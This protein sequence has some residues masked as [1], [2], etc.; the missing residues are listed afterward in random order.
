MSFVH[1]HVHTQYS[2]LDGLSSI[3][4]LLSRAKELGMPA[5]A[6]TDHGN[7]YAIKEFLATAA[8]E[9]SFNNTIKPIVGIEAYV[10]RNDDHRLKG[11]E[12]KYNHLILLAKNYTGYMNLVKLSSIGFI[13][14][15]YNGRARISRPLIEKYHEGL[16]CCSAC[17]AGDIPRK[18]LDGDLKGAREA[19]LWYK[20]VFG[21]DYYLEVQSHKTEIPGLSLEVWEKQQIVNA[22]IFKIAEELGIKVVATNDVHFV[23]KEDGPAHDRLICLTT[24]ASYD[25]PTR[26]RYTQQEYMKSEE[27]MTDLFP[28]HPEV[29]SNTLEVADKVEIYDINRDP[30]LPVY[31][32]PDEFLA[33]IAQYEEKYKEIIDCGRCDAKGNYRGDDFCK[34]VAYLC[35]ITYQGAEER[36]GKVL[37]DEQA[38]RIDFELKTICKMGYP[39]YFLI[40]QDY[41]KAA[42]GMGVP[43]GPGRGSAAGSVVAY[44]LT[45]TNVDPLKYQLLFERF[46]NPDRVSLPD[47][48]VDFADEGR[49]KIFKY[50]EEKYGKDHTSHVVTFGTMAAKGAIKDVAR[51]MSLPIPESTALTKLVGDRPYTMIEKDENGEKVEKEYAIS[52]PNTK[53][54][55]PEFQKAYEEGSELTKEVIDYAE[56]LEGS[57]RQTGVHAC[58][59]IIGRGDLTDYIPISTV[60]D[61]EQGQLLVS[62]YDGHYIESVGMLKMDFLGL[63]TLSIIQNCLRLVKINHGEDIDIEKIDIADAPTFD[64]F[65]RGDTTSVFQ[66]ESPGM[67]SHLMKLKP[68][69]FEDLIAM[70]ALYRPGPMAYIP[71]FIARK[72]GEEKVVY[73]LEG[74]EEI[75]SD[76]YGI[77]V[78]QEQVMLLSQKL[79]GFTKGQADKLRKAMGK[80]QIKILNELEGLFME[81]AIARGHNKEVL[82]KTWS[83]WKEFAKYAFNKSH[84]T[85]YAW[86]AYQTAWLKTHYLPEFQAANLTINLGA[87]DKMKVVMADCKLHNIPILTPDVNESL[88]DFNVNR[89][90][91]IRF[92]F[93]GIK[94]FGSNIG[95]AIIEER[96]ANGLFKDIWDFAERMGLY[97]YEKAK[98]GKGSVSYLTKKVMECLVYS[99]AFDSFGYKREQYFLPTRDGKDIFADAIVAYADNFAKN[100]D[101]AENSLFGGMDEIEVRRPEFSDMP[102]GIDKDI[103][104]FLEILTKEKDLVG[105]YLSNHPLEQYRT[106]IDMLT[107]TT[108]PEIQARVEEGKVG[109]VSL[110]AFVLEAKTM[111][112]QKGSNF[113]SAK[114]EDFD[115]QYDQRFYGARQEQFMGV[116][117][118]HTALLVEGEIRKAFSKE[119]QP[120]VYRFDPVNIN[121]LSNAMDLKTKGLQIFVDTKNVTPTYVKALKSLL[122]RHKGKKPL[123][124]WISDRPTNYNIEFVSHGCPVTISAQLLKE[125][126]DMNII[127]KVIL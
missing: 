59:F 57:I 79:A 77:T 21:D 26:L 39:D 14:G 75:L 61:K 12:Y 114:F 29:I 35:H 28:D 13:E 70:N 98:E 46:L 41:I 122:R 71:S 87:M 69:R 68:D 49:Y 102:S 123:H 30:V 121:L 45:I 19:A 90:G 94:G 89:Q 20:N 10:T 23:R 104:A 40:V 100:K 92:G 62:Q 25:D 86:V 37:T 5:V 64:L 51:V 63:K 74:M 117:Q 55:V 115:G 56:K 116:I 44:C 108:W 7:M 17:I 18:I 80:K 118:P 99:G 78:Y 112:S 65:A 11:K 24:N 85:C 97:S 60:E 9:K 47:I 96:D 67:R 125:L 38:E 83:D 95:A 4:G 107:N 93:G 111:V 127:Y 43:V 113:L 73:E 76:T 120:E 2:I 105:M 42:R 101:F 50:V 52:I 72:H 27:E 109:K 124:V 8:D 34:S 31:Q 106:E 54:C 103:D 15:R 66:F 3:K 33:E 32:L 119:G 22:E 82:E 48:D 6:V 81:G 58:A 110:A 36:Y 16:I 126:R 88:I 53:K 91:E 1:L 84:S